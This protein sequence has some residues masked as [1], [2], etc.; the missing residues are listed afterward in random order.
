[1]RFRR[2]VEF[3][4]DDRELL[5]GIDDIRQRASESL[6]EGFTEVGL[7]IMLVYVDLL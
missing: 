4:R 6:C 1:M 3:G 2:R 5:I 7:T